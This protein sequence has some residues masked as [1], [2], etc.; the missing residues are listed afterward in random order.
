MS[1]REFIIV[2]NHEGKEAPVRAILA[3]WFTVI[4]MSS[5]GTFAIWLFRHNK[6]K[7]GVGCIGAVM[8]LGA[9]YG[10]TLMLEKDLM[11]KQ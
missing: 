3:M 7:L 11:R 2:R 10:I 6:S 4:A 9:V 5:L 1:V 8:I